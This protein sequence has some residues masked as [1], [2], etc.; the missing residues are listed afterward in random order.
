MKDDPVTT[1][2]RTSLI[3]IA[4]L[5]MLFAVRNQ[6]ASTTETQGQQRG[7]RKVAV[8]PVKELPPKA[9]RF[10]LVIGVDD[11]QDTQINRLEGS[12]NDAK[13]LADALVQYAGF[14][15]DQVI[16]LASDQPA[17]RLPTRGNIL[18]FLSN[19]RGLVPEDGL[20]LVSFAGHGIERGGRGYLC[21]SDA[22]TSGTLT[23]L[24]ATA[25]PVEMVREWIR[26]TRVRQVL[27]IVDSCRNNPSGRGEGEN[28]L[29][30]NYAS[31]FNFDVRNQE[32]TAF[33][34]L[35]ATDVG[36]VAYEYKERKQGYFTWALV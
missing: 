2:L 26:D 20:L 29:T 10:A 3:T 12:T 1:T 32:V 35:Y 13:A 8:T 34:T 31:Q 7:N 16:L 9:K 28:E 14:P 23:L 33:A 4:V 18:Q 25:I 6:I 17:Q 27:I 19:L 11:Y 36:N 24:E 15:G 22:R 5:L 21:P 30:Q